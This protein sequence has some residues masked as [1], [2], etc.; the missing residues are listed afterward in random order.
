MADGMVVS[1]WRYPLKSMQGEELNASHLD[2]RACWV[3]VP[4]RSS[5]SRRARW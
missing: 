1:L 2:E 4:S 3:I 5:M